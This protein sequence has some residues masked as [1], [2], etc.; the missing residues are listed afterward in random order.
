MNLLAHYSG[1]NRQV[2]IVGYISA[3]KAGISS[4]LPGEVEVKAVFIDPDSGSMSAAPLH[5][6][7]VIME[8]AKE[9][10]EAT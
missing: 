8:P 1:Y 9:I 5:H 3:Q 4:I 6:F 10:K 7:K 2:Y